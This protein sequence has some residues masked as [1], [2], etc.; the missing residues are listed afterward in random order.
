M[1]EEVKDAPQ[2]EDKELETGKEAPAKEDSTVG[3][4][5]S[6][7]EKKD[8]RLVPEAVLIAEKKARK[9]AEKKLAELEASGA[10]A[11]EIDKTLDGIAEKYGVDEN[12]VNDIASVVKSNAEKD[13]DERIASKM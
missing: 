8:P 6:K 9:E 2:A 5:F 13:L 7:G 3:N 1:A 12:F 10:S 4:L 11:K